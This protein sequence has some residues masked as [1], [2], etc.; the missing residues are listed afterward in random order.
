MESHECKSGVWMGLKVVYI[1]RLSIGRSEDTP[2]V[3]I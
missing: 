3:V 1:G 2:G